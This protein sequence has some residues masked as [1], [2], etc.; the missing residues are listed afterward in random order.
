ML[1]RNSQRALFIHTATAFGAFVESDARTLL[2]S[3]H[4]YIVLAK[5]LMESSYVERGSKHMST[6][7]EDMPA[8]GFSFRNSNKNGRGRMQESV[9]DSDPYV[10]E[11][12]LQ[13]MLSFMASCLMA[14]RTVLF[15]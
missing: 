6:S 14:V 10:S 13:T 8:V 7:L 1:L 4:A 12:G 3:D 9:N 5:F 2:S 11:T 15:H